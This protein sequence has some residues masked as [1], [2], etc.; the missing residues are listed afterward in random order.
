MLKDADEII[1]E[2]SRIKEDFPILMVY[3]GVNKTDRNIERIIEVSK[4]LKCYVV[5]AYLPIL[6][7]FLNECDFEKNKILINRES[8]M[9]KINYEIMIGSGA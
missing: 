6:P 2:I 7:K 4:T 1:H 3:S 9:K 5:M 8:L